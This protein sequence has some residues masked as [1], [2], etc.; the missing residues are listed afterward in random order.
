MKGSRQRHIN[1]KEKRKANIGSKAAGRD[2]QNW[3][4]WPKLTEM[5]QN[6]FR[7][8]IG[9]VSGSGLYTRMVFTTLLVT[10]HL[11]ITIRM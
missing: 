5:D 11:Y 4:E 6:V 8:G 10:N 7:D 9:G 1:Q 2:S 3:P